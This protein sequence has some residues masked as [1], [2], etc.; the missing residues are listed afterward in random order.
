MENLIL[1]V[2]A[3]LAFLGS[4]LGTLVKAHARHRD[5]GGVRRPYHYQGLLFWIWLLVRAWVVGVG[6]LVTL[7]LLMLTLGGSVKSRIQRAFKRSALPAVHSDL[8]A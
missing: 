6:T 8:H 3:C 4:A 7:I 5:A 2:L 1:I